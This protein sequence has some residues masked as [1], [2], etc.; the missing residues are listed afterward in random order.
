MSVGTPETLLHHQMDL[1]FLRTPFI[2]NLM[3]MS[4]GTMIGWLSPATDILMSYE[5]PLQTGPINKEQLSWL[6]SINLLGGIFGTFTFGFI[7]LCL[8]C[9]NTIHT[10]ALAP[11][12]FYALIYFGETIND[13]LIARFVMGEFEFSTNVLRCNHNKVGK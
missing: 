6:A 13:I 2:A 1:I 4:H 9:K 5:T 12:L 3:F 8:G 11:I 10:I 7:V